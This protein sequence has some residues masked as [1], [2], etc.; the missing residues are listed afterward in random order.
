MVSETVDITYVITMKNDSQNRVF[1]LNISENVTNMIL[2]LE[3]FWVFL[4]VID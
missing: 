2:S 3:I 4:S 1:Q